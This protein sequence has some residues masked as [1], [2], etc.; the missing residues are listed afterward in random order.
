MKT[1]IIAFN[2]INSVIRSTIKEVNES[3]SL[4]CDDLIQEAEKN[5]TT[6]GEYNAFMKGASFIFYNIA[7]RNNPQKYGTPPTVHTIEDAINHIIK[8]LP[9]MEESEKVEHLTLIGWLNELLKLKGKK[10][11][12]IPEEFNVI[13]A[14]DA[15]N[16]RIHRDE[17]E[18]MK[19]IKGRAF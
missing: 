12:K 6:K 2:D 1:E 4:L 10:T 17:D 14:L 18:Y 19:S 11:I 5:T 7:K 15:L 3:L 16:S 9:F 8:L 13:E